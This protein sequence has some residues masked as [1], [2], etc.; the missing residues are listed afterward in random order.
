MTQEYVTPL[1]NFSVRKEHFRI[2]VIPQKLAREV[3]RPYMATK[4]E[5]W[6][7]L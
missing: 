6:H 5:K 7:T 1:P 2:T 4:V 3:T